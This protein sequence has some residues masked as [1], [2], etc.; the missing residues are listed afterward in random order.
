MTTPATDDTEGE[1]SSALPPLSL[2]ETVLLFRRGQ[3]GE[4]AHQIKLKTFSP[5]DGQTPA[6][7]VAL[8]ST[9]SRAD[10]VLHIFERSDSAEGGAEG[11]G[12]RA[13]AGQR[14]HNQ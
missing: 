13:A 8:E 7:E 10:V 3:Q 5:E 6:Q 12:E 2:R 4:G 11:E 14:D 9:F 1:A